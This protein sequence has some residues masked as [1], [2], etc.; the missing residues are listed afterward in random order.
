VWQSVRPTSVL[1]LVVI[2]ACTQEST[3]VSQAAG[4]AALPSETSPRA[5]VR[6]VE[7]VPFARCRDGVPDPADHDFA[8]KRSVVM[9]RSLPPKHYAHDVAANPGAKVAVVGKFAY[10][11]V[12]KDLE[13]EPVTVWLDDCAAVTSIA[14]GK[15]D[16]DGRAAIEITAPAKPGEY[17]LHFVVGGDGSSTRASLW[18]VERGTPVVVFDIDGT[19]TE[20][21]AEVNKDVLDEHFA[22][23]VGGDYAPKIYADG[24]VLADTWVDKGVLPIYVSGRPYWL[25][26][27]SRDW[28]AG[29]NFPRGLVRTTDRHREV[30]PKIE[31]VG[32]FKAATLRRLLELGVDVQAAYGNA[33]TD[34]WAYADVGI[35]RERTFIIGPHAGK[36]GTRAVT[37]AWTSAL[38]WARDQPVPN[39]ALALR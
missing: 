26:Q 35:P 39:G 28:L 6:K 3:V 5:V 25:S 4:V 37:D 38:P 19:L 17:A 23:M 11:D 1:A 36:D 8:H 20:S 31:G 15:T 21:D 18:V 27:Y 29:E 10:G 2:A 33:T 13:D 7:R 14:S 34:I 9:A 32:Q 22:A 30:V 24:A 12:G 16:D